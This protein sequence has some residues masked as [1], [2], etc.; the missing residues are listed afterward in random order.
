MAPADLDARWEFGPHV[1]TVADA[2]L[3]AAGDPET[4]SEI[5]FRRGL[6]AALAG[7]FLWLVYE[8]TL[9]QLGRWVITGKAR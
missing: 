2:I 4:V 8:R 1:A 3:Y 7:L 9:G 5:W 6:I